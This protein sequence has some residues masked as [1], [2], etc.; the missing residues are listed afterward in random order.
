MGLAQAGYRTA[1]VARDRERLDAACRAIET[2]GGEALCCAADLGDPGAAAAVTAWVRQQLGPVAVLVNNAG[3]APSDRI[4]NTTDEMLRATFDL[5]VRAPLALLRA[6]LPDLRAQPAAAVV[7]LAST[8]G[9]RG[10][11]F[12]AAYT[13]AKHGMV[14]LTRAAAAEL[15]STPIRI[16]AVCPGFVDTDITRAAAATIAARGKSSVEGAL[17][18]L[19]A[20]NRIGRMHRPEEVAAAVLM[21]VRERPAGCVYDLDRRTPAFVDQACENPEQP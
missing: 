6:C 9:L 14:G 5:H 17:Q 3:T 16:Y 13:A 20:Q 1:L 12:T 19:G 21:L 4:E 2:A 10:F 7:N 18:R 8:A 15:Q 11:A